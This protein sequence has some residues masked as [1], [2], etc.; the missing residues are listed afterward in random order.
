MTT[1][2]ETQPYPAIGPT[3]EE[4]ALPRN[5]PIVSIS[6]QDDEATAAIWVAASFWA[7]M[8]FHLR[9]WR[10]M[11]DGS[12][13]W[14]EIRT[15]PLR[16]S[17]GTQQWIC[18]KADIDDQRTGQQ[19][20]TKTASNPPNGDDAV[21]AAKIVERLLGNAWAFDAAGRPTY[22]TPIAQAFVAA[23]LDEFQAA[24]DEGRLFFKLTHPDDYDRTAAAWRHSLKTGDPFFIERRVRRA[25]GIHEWTR[26]AIVPT[27]DGQG[28]ITGWYGSMMDLDAYRT[29]ELALRDREREL[30]QLVDMVP[31]HIWRLTPDGEPVFFNRR[32][33]DFLGID[34]PDTDRPGTS[35]MEAFI[36]TVH[37]SD[38]AVFRGVLGRCLITG[39]VFS[40]RYRLRRADGVYRWMSS[41]AE[42]L[43]DE[44]GRIVQWYG[45]CHDIDDEMRAQQAEEALRQASDKLAQAT[46]AASLAE[47]SASIAHEVNQPLAAI[48]ANSHACQ[49]WLTVEPPNMERAQ[50]TIERIIRDANAASDVVNRIRA[51]FRQSLEPRTQ[52]AFSSVIDD[53]RDLMADEA[54]RRRVRTELDVESNL[55]L[56]A[57]DRVQVQ[58]V[59][60]NLMRNGL[61]AMDSAAGDRVLGVRVRRLGDV[62]QTEINDC[63]Q[64]VEFPEKIFEPFFTTKENGMGMGL[65]I[66]RSI[67]ESHG[68][69][70]W[71]E[72][73]ERRGATFIF[74]LP[75]DVKTAP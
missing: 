64:G 11:P 71:V 59:L 6:A 54:S 72:K 67:V 10:G 21:L 61:E 70:L 9:Y 52:T 28:R 65:A 23:T 12:Y 55:P 3:P 56:V 29:A 24:V 45:L 38:A 33:V 44:G 26:T 53:V 49:R 74:T 36:E 18:T 16:E 25:T 68:G 57:F 58:Q 8:S 17:G 60:I 14:T 69:R 42:P 2:A 43:R 1:H 13:R 66:C 15:E 48:V 51:L 5:S 39:E 63:G 73:N 4:K 20:P 7:G 75:V 32:M 34:I 47:L 19:Q 46:R 30:S 27:R 22:L 50:K 62:V 37:P 40:M 35:R 41:L 31:S